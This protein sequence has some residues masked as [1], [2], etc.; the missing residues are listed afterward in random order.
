MPALALNKSRSGMMCPIAK[1]TSSSIKMIPKRLEEFEEQSRNYLC[2]ASDK[3]RKAVQAR[4]RGR[5]TGHWRNPMTTKV[6]ITFVTTGTFR[7]SI[8]T[9]S[10]TTDGPWY[11]SVVGSHTFAIVFLDRGYKDSD[12]SLHILICFLEKSVSQPM[13]LQR[14]ASVPCADCFLRCSLRA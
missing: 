2:D 11:E 9:P 13:S 1:G 4:I 5:L 6:I 7:V 3:D 8:S 10:G 14:G 12:L